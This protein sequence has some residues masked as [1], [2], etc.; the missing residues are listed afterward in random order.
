M[1]KIYRARV[2]LRN[3]KRVMLLLILL[4]LLTTPLVFAEEN[5]TLSSISTSFGQ[6]LDKE[7]PLPD[8][9]KMIVKLVL[10]VKQSPELTISILTILVAVWII[11]FLILA[12]ILELTP[13]F[14]G[15]TRWIGAA[16]IALI[17]A[18][19]GVIES[20]ALFLIALS[21]DIIFFGQFSAGALL[22]VIIILVVSW[23]VLS[24]ISR[25]IKE[26]REISE[27]HIEGTKVGAELGFSRRLREMFRFTRKP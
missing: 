16:C 22:F 5:K 19:T 20:A 6:S 27:A 10:G 23:V 26:Y 3:M 14:H 12:N 4:S 24:K 8:S 25:L 11:I 18:V 17:I 2:L 7:V 13:F 21:R 15:W 9:V 1:Q